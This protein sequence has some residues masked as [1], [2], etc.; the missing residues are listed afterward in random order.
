MKYDPTGI[1]FEAF[2]QL[3]EPSDILFDFKTKDTNTPVKYLYPHAL[4]DATAAV[5]ELSAK[6]GFIFLKAKE[7]SAPQPISFFTYIKQILLFNYYARPRWQKLWPFTLSKATTTETPM[8][9][10]LLP[11]T[12]CSS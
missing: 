12:S 2:T 4:G 6:F 10:S 7:K 1:W 9:F 8:P 3:G 5:T 11:K